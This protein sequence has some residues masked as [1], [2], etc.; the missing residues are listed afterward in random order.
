MSLFFWLFTFAIT[1]WHRKFVTSDVTA[2]FVDNQRGIQ[3]RGQDFY[4]KFVFE[5]IHSKEV[6][7]E[8]SEK[9][10]TKRGVNKLLKRCE[11]HAQFTGGQKFEF[12]IF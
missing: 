8:F 4:K 5:V 12:L 2:V 9:R 7:D 3:R 11:T 1:S 6:Q 10:W